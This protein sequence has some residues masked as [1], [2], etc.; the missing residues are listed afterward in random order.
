MLSA[1]SIE[2][3][4]DGTSLLVWDPACSTCHHCQLGYR[5]LC[6]APVQCRPRAD[7]GSQPGSGD[8]W[9]MRSLTTPLSPD[10]VP[11]LYD[12]AAAV[13]LMCA[14]HLCAPAVL[15]LGTGRQA[16]VAGTVLAASG[17]GYVA[18]AGD[19]P[20]VPGIP[21][22]TDPAEVRLFFDHLAGPQRADVVITFDGDL[23]RAAKS[24]R[25]G[26]FIGAVG[27]VT[28]M[29]APTTMAQRELDIL[30]PRD[31]VEAL[32][33]MDLSGRGVCGAPGEQA[34]SKGDNAISA[35]EA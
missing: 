11:Y 35:R 18:I 16:A 14:A 4:E 24:V 10:L 30:T 7:N 9:R 5:A 25:R 27:S 19:V 22:S 21:S 28:Q 2:L 8:R 6:T 13:D 17:A 34:G 1:P 3:G 12:S 20:P 31:I 15:V 23:L 26:G 33:T 32:M 29:P